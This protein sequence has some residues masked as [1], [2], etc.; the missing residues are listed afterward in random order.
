MNQNP[1]YISVAAQ[2]PGDPCAFID[3]IAAG[4]MKCGAKGQGWVCSKTPPFS[5]VTP[6]QQVEI[7]HEVRMLLGRF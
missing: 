2:H 3:A 5:P 6:S 4:L 1:N 7:L